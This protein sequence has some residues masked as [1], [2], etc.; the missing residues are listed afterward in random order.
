RPA[1]RRCRR[2]PGGRRRARS[3]TWW[4]SPGARGGSRGRRGRGPRRSARTSQPIS[5]STRTRSALVVVVGLVV[6]DLPVTVLLAQE[7][8]A[9][10]L[11]GLLA[12]EGLEGL[13][14]VAGVFGGGGPVDACGVAVLL[15]VAGL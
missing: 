1:D 6:L 7:R 10:V 14:V 13:V 11:L 9:L 5:R 15:H 2:T 4:R 3:P 12:A 8:G